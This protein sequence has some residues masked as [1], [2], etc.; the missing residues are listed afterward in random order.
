METVLKNRKLSHAGDN[1]LLIDGR[2]QPLAVGWHA[3]FLEARWAH[4]AG[5]MPGTEQGYVILDGML[6]A[7]REQREG[8]W[9]TINFPMIQHSSAIDI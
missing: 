4:L 5:N 9:K 8:S 6:S 3:E 7:A 2:A 1:V